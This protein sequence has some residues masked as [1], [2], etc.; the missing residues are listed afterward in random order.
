MKK[1]MKTNGST[2]RRRK[3]SKR[4]NGPRVVTR[5]LLGHVL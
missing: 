1:K 5:P 2:Y 4:K 3:S